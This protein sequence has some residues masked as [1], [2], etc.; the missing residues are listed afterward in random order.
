MIPIHEHC[1]LVIED[2]AFIALEVCDALEQAGYRIAGPAGTVQ[3]AQQLIAE[4]APTLAVVDIQLRDGPCTSI[5]RQLR[6]RG[7]PFV[8]HSAYRQGDAIASEFRGAPWCAKPAWPGDL[9]TLLEA[10]PRNALP[11]LESA[12]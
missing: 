10:L 11:Q 6:E 9:L 8:V 7:V 12:P 3:H 5:A 1:V 4:Q 2:D